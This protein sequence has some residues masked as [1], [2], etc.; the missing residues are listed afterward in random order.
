ML[1]HTAVFINDSQISHKTQYKDITIYNVEAHSCFYKWQPW[2]EP[3][4]VMCQLWNLYGGSGGRSFKHSQLSDTKCQSLLFQ[5]LEC[6]QWWGKKLSENTWF[7]TFRC[8]HY[9]FKHFFLHILR[10]VSLLNQWCNQCWKIKMIAEQCVCKIASFFSIELSPYH[11]Q[12]TL[13]IRQ[14]LKVFQKSEKF[15][16]N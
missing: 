3:G 9:I 15:C 2:E 1:E 14:I 12:K 16:T 11:F 8:Y 6:P 10:I 13:S 5:I 4:F 7:F